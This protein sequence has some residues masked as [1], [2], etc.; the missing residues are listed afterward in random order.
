MDF[1]LKRAYEPAVAFDGERTL[2]EHNDA[3]VLAEILGRGR[4]S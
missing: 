3:V 1:R 4:R 2:I